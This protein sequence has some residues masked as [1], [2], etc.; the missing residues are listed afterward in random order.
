ML[1]LDRVRE[2][3]DDFDILHFHIDQ[4]HFPLFPPLLVPTRGVRHLI[5]HRR[6]AGHVQCFQR[7]WL[8][9]W[10]LKSSTLE[11]NSFRIG[12]LFALL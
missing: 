6:E 8:D 12:D 2:C 9:I 11:R 4:F 1:M 5:D 10:A 3:A 7:A